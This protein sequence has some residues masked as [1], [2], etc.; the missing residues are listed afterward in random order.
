MKHIQIVTTL[1]AA[2]FALT[3]ISQAEEAKAP[4]GF[5]DVSYN[6][7]DW[8]AGTE[9]KSIKRDFNYLEIEAGAQYGW[10][11]LYGFFDLENPAMPS[12]DV[13]TAGKGSINYSLFST[14]LSLYGHVYNF[15]AL[16]FSEQNR[17]LGLGY[18][19]GGPGWWFKPFVGVH[20][21]TQTYTSGFNGYMAGWVLGYFFT[22]KKQTFMLSNWHEH[23][24]SRQRAYT[25]GNGGKTTSHN[26]AAALWW[27]PPSK[28]SL[29][30]QWRYAT[31]KLGTPGAM[32]AMIYTIKFVL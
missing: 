8:D 25:R 1:L 22:V 23:E 26:G 20:D 4:T 12:G 13:R 24:F 10:G 7:L 9:G 16:G 5:A 31:D 17:V 19:W 18:S 3:S 27:A 32:N 21:V 30:V 15:T 29:G 28:L 14:K 2:F 11:E 6:R